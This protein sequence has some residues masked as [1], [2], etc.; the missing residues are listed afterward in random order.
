MYKKTIIQLPSAFPPPCLGLRL[1][2]AVGIALAIALLI[3]VAT[4][5]PMHL[6]IAFGCLVEA[7]WMSCSW[8]LA[9][10]WEPFGT[11]WTPR[12][13]FFGAR[14]DAWPISAPGCKKVRKSYKLVELW[15]LPGCPIW[16]Y[17]A[18]FDEFLAACFWLFFWY[19]F[20]FSQF[21]VPGSIW[22][23]IGDA[24]WGTWDPRK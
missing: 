19:P 5:F 8:L 20:F 21:A 12:A 3:E 15:W 13:T 7:F 17:F 24:F 10:F 4:E 22:D 1:P 16:D 9:T 18:A 14:D 23:P 11:F 2:T 6:L